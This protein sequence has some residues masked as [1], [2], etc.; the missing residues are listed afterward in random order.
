MKNVFDIPASLLE[1]IDQ[2]TN[3]VS[4]R[5]DLDIRPLV[6]IAG[7]KPVGVN[8][9]YYGKAED[10]STKESD[11]EHIH[12]LLEIPKPKQSRVAS[13]TNT[14][15]RIRRSYICLESSA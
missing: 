13:S 11:A 15:N 6:L 2:V 1:A 7:L 10:F 3:H 4:W 8:E 9:V 5:R 14:Y 12:D